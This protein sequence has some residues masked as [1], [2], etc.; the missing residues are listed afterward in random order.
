MITIK[1]VV[2][3][4]QQVE[5]PSI[6]LSLIELGILTEIELIDNDVVVVFAFPFP[7]I[8]IADQ[9]IHSI[10]KPINQLG[11]NLQYQIRTM[12]SEEKQRFLQLEASAWKG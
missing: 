12:S 9:L 4:M 3:V 8:P 5:H 2:D 10:E 1:E 11:L 6:R 7:N